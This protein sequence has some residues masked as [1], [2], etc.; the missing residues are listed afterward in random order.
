M[1]SGARTMPFEDKDAATR[2]DLWRQELDALKDAEDTFHEFS[3]AQEAQFWADKLTLTRKGS[4]DYVAVFHLM[5]EAKKAAQREDFANL[6]EDYNEQI[7]ANKNNA[8]AQ[9]AIAHQRTETIKTLFGEESKEYKRALNDEIKVRQDWAAKELQILAI[10]AKM[11]EASA[12]HEVKM[13]QLALDQQVALRRVSNEQKFAME[14]QF[15]NR[16]YQLKL[17]EMQ[18][19]LAAEKNGPNDPVRVAQIEAQI[20]GL[21][22]THQEK[23]TQIHNAAVLEREKFALQ[24]DDAIKSSLGDLIASLT[25]RTK[26]LSEKLKSFVDSLTQQLSRIAANKLIEDLLGAGTQGGGVISDITRRIF[27]GGPLGAASGNPALTTAGTTLTSAGGLLQSAAAA[28]TSAAGALTAG[29]FGGSLGGA[30]GGG[31]NSMFGGGMGDAF[32]MVGLP[33]FDDG[34][35]YVPKDTLAF[36]HKGEAVVPARYNTGQSSSNQRTLHMRV[37]NNFNGP[38]DTRTQNQ[39][40]AANYRASKRAHKYL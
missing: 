35:N 32:S 37:T 27:G 24:A 15:E 18:S 25:D 7:T 20:E 30:F 31:I 13:E 16:L 22:Q 23:L 4:K 38:I 29:G 39:I 2:L 14:E 12:E 11:V 40:A 34:T 21:E 8:V 33:F 1:K 26:T 28:L 19:L 3:K 9:I 5:V 36:I 17:R 6:M 10:H